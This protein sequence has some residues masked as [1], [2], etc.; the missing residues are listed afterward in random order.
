MAQRNILLIISGGISAYKCLELVRRLADRHIKVRV[1][2]T[3]SAQRFI[4]PLSVSALTNDRVFTDLFD[5][6]DEREIGHIRLSRESDLI[7]VAPAT[8]NLIAKM[9]NGLADDLATAVLLATDKPVLVAPAMNPHMWRHKATIRN[10]EQLRSD[11]IHVLEPATGEMAEKNE[12]GQGRLPEVPQLV[13]EIETRLNR[14]IDYETTGSLR[15][16]L[17]G[18]HVLITS[19]P[20]HEPIDP[21]RYIANRSSGKQGFALA[22]AAASS[23]ARVTLITGPVTLADPEGV[24]TI[25]VQTAEEMLEA[26]QKALPA[27]ISIFAAAVADWRVEKVQAAKIKKTADPKSLS[28]KLRENPDILKTVASLKQGR[29]KLVIGFAA[30]TNDVVS[31]AKKKLKK[32]GADWIVANDVSHKTGIMGG[33]HN[34]VFI[35][36]NTGIQE[37]PQMSKIKVAQRLMSLAAD[38]LSAHHTSK[39]DAAQ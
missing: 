25:H 18:R 32:K 2:M 23:G 16:A 20:T 8:A 39:Q 26:V 7:V 13:H 6:N 9:A 35:I 33:E 22:R 1:V 21:V 36:Q 17:A 3:Q 19:G 34:R 27:D 4:T 14:G 29:P 24:K 15:G 30:E 5:L 11:G 28:L 38:F 10:V 31:F 12:S 37:W